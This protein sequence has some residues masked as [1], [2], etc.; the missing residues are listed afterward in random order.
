MSNRAGNKG[1]NSGVEPIIMSIEISKL[2]YGLDNIRKSVEY[3]HTPVIPETSSLLPNNSMVFANSINPYFKDKDKNLLEKI[4]V[5]ERN[6]VAWYPKGL[7]L[8]GGGL[9]IGAFFKNVLKNKNEVT[10][11]VTS[12]SISV[13]GSTENIENCRVRIEVDP[14]TSAILVSF[15]KKGN[16]KIMAI[17]RKISKILFYKRF[18][19]KRTDHKDPDQVKVESRS[20]ILDLWGFTVHSLI[21]FVA[22]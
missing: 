14:N 3:K 16:K 18:K 13:T 8:L 20:A 7:L 9:N 19:T 1:N 10:I 12:D 17:I 21:R 22:T 15:V 11:E 6:T 5:S 4:D 2:L